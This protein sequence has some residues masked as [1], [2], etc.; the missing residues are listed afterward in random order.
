MKKMKSILLI[1]SCLV[2]T[3]LVSAQ[4]TGKKM[5]YIKYEGR[6]GSNEGICLFKDGRFMLYGYATA[7]FGN[8]LFEKD[9]MLFYPDK[10]NRFEVYATQNKSI[11]DT[12]R[13][14]FAGFDRGRK[15]FVRF[16]TDSIHRVFNEDANCFNGP[17]VYELS[18][19]ITEFTL[20]G[21]MEEEGWYS[22]NPVESWTF[23]NKG[24]YNDFIFSYAAPKREYENFSAK[25]SFAENRSVIKLSNYG[26]DNGYF[27][28]TPDEDEQRQWQ[29]V[30][31]MKNRYEQGR[32]AI[33]NGVYANKHYR[34]SLPDLGEYTF[35]KATNQYISRDAAEN[36]AY[37]RDNQYKDDRF[38]RHYVK[39][40]PES[41]DT[42]DFAKN[43]VAGSSIFFTTCGEGAERSYYYK[44]LKKEPADGVDAPIPTTVAPVPMPN[45]PG[46]DTSE[47]TPS[48]TP[49]P[50][51]LAPVIDTAIASASGTMP[52]SDTLAFESEP[53]RIRKE[54]KKDDI[55][56]LEEYENG[57]LI[58]KEAW[59][60]NK[61][62]ATVQ[63][64]KSGKLEKR[65]EIT[66]RYSLADEIIKTYNSKGK[67][68]QRKVASLENTSIIYHIYDGNGKL[69]KVERPL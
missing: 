29:E 35:D 54:Y 38:L 55:T 50:D 17:F 41:R 23:K 15:T 32:K 16:G 31:E 8:Y 14:N 4:N 11:G 45:D 34:V 22:G 30:L 65:E 27:K 9:Y 21:L 28:N 12:T 60:M 51:T 57:E 68:I 61:N 62:K 2:S 37:F 5:Q 40:K 56:Y 18:N 19:Q 36:E 63:Y 66:N 42:K 67:L 13:I 58:R 39:L 46:S 49:L 47:V 6:Y 69:L 44:D 7:V 53:G 52:L 25:M 64:F 33:N 59:D 48:D 24:Q 3:L 1:L 43:E 10:D 26:G 20:T